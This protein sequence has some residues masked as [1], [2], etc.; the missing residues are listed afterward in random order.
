M[1]ETYY[2][3]DTTTA[4][5]NTSYT[6]TSEL[7]NK[8]NNNITIRS[9]D[10]NDAATAG[11]TNIGN[12]LWMD[13]NNTFYYDTSNTSTITTSGWQ[14]TSYTY[15]PGYYSSTAGYCSTEWDT[16]VKPLE[17][18]IKEK[19]EKVISDE[20]EMM[21]LVKNYLRKYLEKV[22]DAP[23]EIINDLLKKDKEIEEQKEAIKDLKEEINRLKKEVME[24]QVDRLRVKGDGPSP[25][26]PYDPFGPTTT[27]PSITW[28]GTICDASSSTSA[29]YSTSN[30]SEFTTSA[31]A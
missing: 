25:Y 3:L 6:T 31:K 27:S 16:D 14:G 26:N 18:T 5:D 10:A 22:M 20:D 17:D 21:P 2:D 7:F 29:T 11:Y 28:G 30:T 23:E 9:I 19:I 1:G 13:N 4:V 24:L 12:G 15:S 8:L